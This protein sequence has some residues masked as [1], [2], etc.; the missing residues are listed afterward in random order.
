MN[1]INIRLK[2]SDMKEKELVTIINSTLSDFF[3]KN[4]AYDKY[5]SHKLKKQKFTGLKSPNEHEDE[6]IPYYYDYD[7]FYHNK[8]MFN[9]VISL[10]PNKNSNNETFTTITDI[11]Y[12]LS[13]R[14]TETFDIDTTCHI[15]SIKHYSFE[16][17]MNKIIDNL[18]CEKTF[19]NRDSY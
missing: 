12:I 7:Y 18:P 9:I 11:S 8:Y 13:L 19:I 17:L 16:S 15:T 4:K 1:V 6:S 2:T 10:Y 5:K 3:T 14:A